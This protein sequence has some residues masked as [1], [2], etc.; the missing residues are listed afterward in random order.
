MKKN[1]LMP[2]F[3]IPMLLS[4]CTY[5]PLFKKPSFK[6]AHNQ[7]SQ[8]EFISELHRQYDEHQILSSSEPIESDLVCEGYEYRSAETTLSTSNN[9]QLWK[10][11]KIR[12]VDANIKYDHDTEICSIN[13]SYKVKSTENYY[14][15][16]SYKDENETLVK[17][18]YIQSG[19]NAIAANE[20]D[21]VYS[22]STNTQVN[23]VT[24]ALLQDLM[25]YLDF[26]YITPYYVDPYK[27]T[28]ELLKTYVDDKLFTL[29]YKNSVDNQTSNTEK[30]EDLVLKETI[31]VQMSLKK[32][33]SIALLQEVK[34]TRKYLVD[35]AS[36]LKGEIETYNLKQYV[37]YQVR[38]KKNS[39]KPVDYSSFF[40]D[41]S[42]N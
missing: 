25:S 32:D 40:K 15:A 22:I 24:K 31:K 33:P 35:S 34:A 12:A 17:Y 11:S 7:V 30:S 13:G 42:Q 28:S 29:V 20:I 19:D 26:I 39:L 21:E 36:H 5:S 4:S 2:L 1:A 16:Y 6:A 23:E 41:E 3:A 38:L 14:N 10:T 9:K 8:E 18:Q 37:K 27:E